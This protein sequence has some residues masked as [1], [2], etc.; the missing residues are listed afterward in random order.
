MIEV[1]CRR[2]V[3]DRAALEEYQQRFPAHSGMLRDAWPSLAC[4]QDHDKTTHSAVS[5]SEINHVPSQNE[6]DTVRKWRYRPHHCSS[7][8][9]RSG[10][11]LGTGGFGVV[12]LAYEEQFR[13]HVAIKVPH[14]N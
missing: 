2:R 12:Y 4:G 9:T 6:P 1:E 10:P 11:A 3:G 5:Q 13:C 8:V 14:R 7:V